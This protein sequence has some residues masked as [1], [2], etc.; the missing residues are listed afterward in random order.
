M[1][2]T[3]PPYGRSTGRYYHMYKEKAQRGDATDEAKG[4]ALMKL[5][6]GAIEEHHAKAA[7]APQA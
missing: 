7:A 5:V 2:A 6:D 3:E 4:E 1:L